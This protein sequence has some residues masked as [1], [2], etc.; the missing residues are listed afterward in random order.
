MKNNNPFAY[1]TG[2]VSKTKTREAREIRRFYKELHEEVKREIR[3]IDKSTTNTTTTR[4]YLNGLERS[5]SKSL[6][7]IANNSQSV[8]TGGV[9]DVTGVMSELNQTFLK[10]IGF[11]DYISAPGLKENMANR[12]LTGQIYDGKWSL[13]SSIWGNNNAQQQKIREIV[14]KGIVFNKSTKE[15]AKELEKYLNP[16]APGNVDYNTQRLAKTMT[17]H[18][19]QQAFVQLTRYNPFIDA[20]RWITSGGHNVCALCI[21]REETDAYGLGPGIFP[22]DELPL[23]HPNGN[24]TWE[25]VTSYTDEQVADYINDWY[26][27]EGDY[28]M[29]QEIDR[30]MESLQEN[31]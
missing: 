29:N 13:S 3:N 26:F 10:G 23:D 4:S 22:K 15:V 20:Y 7:D 14:S 19:Y 27:D 16:N 31:F 25:I 9:K 12:V 24:C 1:A 21:D 5:I 17:Q 28:F 6:N 11:Y 2:F 30:F 18:A 8:I